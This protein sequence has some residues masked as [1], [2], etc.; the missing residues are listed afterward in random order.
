MMI[1]LV[2]L[3]LLVIRYTVQFPTFRFATIHGAGHMAPA[4]RPAQ[5]L[6]AFRRY[7][8]GEW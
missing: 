5:T 7:L 3:L 8:S 1:A 2:L 4:T 6:E